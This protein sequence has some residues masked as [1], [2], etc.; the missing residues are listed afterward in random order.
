MI[1]DAYAKSAAQ[2]AVCASIAESNQT[3]DESSSHFLSFL[4]TASVARDMLEMMDKAGVEKL[5][6][7]GFSYGTYL[8]GVFASMWPEKVERL[9]SDGECLALYTRSL[10]LIQLT[11]NVD[12]LEWSSGTQINCKP[13]FPSFVFF[14]PSPAIS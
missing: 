13:N 14:V 5:R 1:F 8:G 9:V 4:S 3:S 12:Y 7:W 2:S 10:V 6:Y 11:G